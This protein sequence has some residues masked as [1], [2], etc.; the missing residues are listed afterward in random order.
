MTRNAKLILVLV[1]A[2]LALGTGLDVRA[3]D[4]PKELKIS[5]KE[6]RVFKAE[7]DLVTIKGVIQAVQGEVRLSASDIV[8]D[9]K[10]KFATISGGVELTQSDL[11]L[12]ATKVSAWFDEERYLLETGVKVTKKEKEAGKGDKL[13]L[14]AEQMEYDAKNRAMKATGSV[15]VGQKNRSATADS[16]TYRDRESLVILEGNVVVTERDDKAEKDEKTIRGD[17]ITIDLDKD[18]VE[19]EGPVEVDFRL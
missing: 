16:V 2:L 8:Y 12:S 15:K 17:K 19:V 1:A 7:K 6:N 18:V 9:T 13:T 4:K 10:K 11:V 3:G 5:V 14:A